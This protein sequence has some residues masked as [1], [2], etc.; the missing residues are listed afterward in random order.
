[1]KIERR[2]LL[3]SSRPDPLSVGCRFDT[4]TYTVILLYVTSEAKV[5]AN[6]EAIFGAAGGEREGVRRLRFDCGQG[7]GQGREIILK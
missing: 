3:V 4:V 6:A 2:T 5:Q 1:M 7:Q